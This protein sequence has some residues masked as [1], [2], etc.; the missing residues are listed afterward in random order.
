MDIWIR[1]LDQR[2]RLPPSNTAIGRRYQLRYAYFIANEYRERLK[3]AVI[4]QSLADGW[5]SLNP[6]YKEHKIRTGLNPG[7][8][9]ATERLIESIVV[10][11]YG[12]EIQVGIDRRKVE[13]VS[14]TP[15]HLIAKALE[16]GT[17]T[18]PA[19]PLF[20]P[21]LLSMYRDIDN[22]TARFLQEVM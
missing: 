17:D 21:V 12:M 9:V 22:I 15:L 13:K 20:R 6:A 14:R 16:Y 19:R 8:W 18:I 4:R 10:V 11:R 3:Q 5:V 2:M 1:E 7:M